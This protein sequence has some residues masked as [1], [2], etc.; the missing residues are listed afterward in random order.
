MTYE[1]EKDEYKSSPFIF[2]LLVG[3]KYM[4][5]RPDYKIL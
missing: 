3:N 5:L 2:D 4:G 1:V